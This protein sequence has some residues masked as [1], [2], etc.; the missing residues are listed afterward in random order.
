MSHQSIDGLRG[1]LGSVPPYI[2]RR[3]DQSYLA[4]QPWNAHHKMEDLLV[5]SKS[6][7]L[8]QEEILLAIM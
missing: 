3:A 5:L 8:A 2:C 6:Q 1:S 7:L 4:L